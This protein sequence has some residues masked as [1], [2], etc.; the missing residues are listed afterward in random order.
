MCKLKKIVIFILS[1]I[2]FSSGLPMKSFADLDPNSISAS[3]A[4]VICA[5]NGKVLFEKNAYEK[6]SMASTTKIMTALLALEA[7]DAED[8]DISITNKM[9][10]VEGSSMGLKEGNILP[11][12]SL[13]KG[14]LTVSG[15]DAANAVAI[16]LGGSLEL[17]SDM[18]N[19]KAKQIGC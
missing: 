5:D 4:V 17:F 1:F 15:N 6:R 18:M 14:M 2:I 9:I 10:L 12:S 7:A 13:A 11:I 16:S 3:S 8:R 19:E